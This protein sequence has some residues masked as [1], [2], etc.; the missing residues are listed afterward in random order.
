MSKS[1]TRSFLKALG[2]TEDQQTSIL[3]Q[4]SA[5]VDE[6]KAERDTY[7]EEA[8]K[9]PGVQKELDALKGGE[10]YKTKWETEHKAFEDYKSQVAKDAET[11]KVKSAYKQLLIDEK[12]N[13]KLVDD[14]VRLAD[15]DK[16]KLDKDGNLENI[17]ALKTTINDKYSAYK[18][19]TELRTHKPETPP[20]E[21]NDGGNSE[22]KAMAAKW[23]E[24]R[25]G[26]QKND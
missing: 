9:L 23:R 25:Y 10:D 19:K 2:L 8:D 22:I 12:I 3:E 18:V 16:M 7:K 13:P 11:A 14:L 20:K 17:D 24:A 6:I 15:V 5:V 4:H 21:E 26:K 1:L